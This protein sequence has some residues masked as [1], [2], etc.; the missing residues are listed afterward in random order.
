M[1]L[2]LHKIKYSFI[3]LLLV[4]IFLCFYKV[5]HAQETN[6]DLSAFSFH[7]YTRAAL[8]QS[9]GGETAASFKAPGAGAK[10]RLGN[11][12]DTL[13]RLRVNYTGKASSSTEPY[14]NAEFAMQGYEAFG[15]TEDFELGDVPKAYLQFVNY[16]GEGVSVW[17]GRRWYERKGSYINDYWWINSGQ[18]ANFGF[19]VEGI[20]LFD[21]EVKVAA[22]FHED[23]VKGIEEKSN[24]SG[25]LSSHTIDVRWLNIPLTD[26]T[27]LNFWGLGAFRESKQ[28]LGYEDETGFGIGTWFDTK[29]FFGGKNTLAFTYRTG[30]AITQRSTY[31]RP[32]S[33][34]N[35]YVLN[36]ASMWEI[37]QS[38]TWDNNAS[39]AIQWLTLARGDKHG[40]SGVKGD[41]ITWLSSGARPVLYL[42]RHWSLATEL[43]IDYVDN[44]IQGV[45][46]SLGKLS[47]ALQVS[48][49]KAFMSR[50]VLRVFATYAQWGSE[51]EGYVGNS[52]A[53][54][55]YG[56]DDNGWTIGAQVEHIW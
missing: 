55:P 4:N 10:Y 17:L 38:W 46:G 27:K 2:C 25:D 23:G 41:T 53:N 36:D 21:G 31:S 1:P 8:A 12:S 44:E 30:P 45:K 22:F 52:P 11:E 32:I 28:S 47:V 35:G 29:S 5:A 43:G 49:E 14:I 18:W 20:K 39:Y 54:A 33:E 15:N 37:N 9:E 56:M 34:E 3:C 48:P 13:L 16:L 24:K 40:V 7:G 42:N 50:P 26:N 51:L 19:G 6:V